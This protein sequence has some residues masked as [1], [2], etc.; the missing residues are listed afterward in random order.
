MYVEAAF[1]GV[2][3]CPVG[4]DSGRF[5]SNRSCIPVTCFMLSYQ[6]LQHCYSAS[7]CSQK[8]EHVPYIHS[9]N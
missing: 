7:I 5:A 4:G 3:E 8:V 9:N 2:D 1:W 6:D